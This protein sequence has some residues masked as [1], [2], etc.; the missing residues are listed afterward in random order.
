MYEK[1]IL[2]LKDASGINSIRT[3]NVQCIVLCGTIPQEEMQIKSFELYRHALN[4]IL[5]GT[6]FIAKNTIDDDKPIKKNYVK[7]QPNTLKLSTGT[8]FNLITYCKYLK[9]KERGASNAEYVE[10]INKKPITHKNGSPYCDYTSENYDIT[11]LISAMQLFGYNISPYNDKE[12]YNIVSP[13]F[14]G[15]IV[16]TGGHWYVHKKI[17]KRNAHDHPLFVH[18]DSKDTTDPN[19]KTRTF[20]EILEYEN[21]NNHMQMLYTVIN[22]QPRK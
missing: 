13:T 21:T 14:I 16:G 6:Y 2:F 4:N 3:Y 20:N 8:P 9:I 1:N 19:R 10:V 22:T 17:D 12:L 11:L 18:I 15:F 5:G 7:M